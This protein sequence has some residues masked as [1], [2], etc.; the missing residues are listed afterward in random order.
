MPEVVEDIVVELGDRSTHREPYQVFKTALKHVNKPDKSAEDMHADDGLYKNRIMEQHRRDES[1]T[2]LGEE[3]MYQEWKK[4]K[5]EEK[6]RSRLEQWEMRLAEEE[7]EG[8]KKEDREDRRQDDRR[9]R[10]AWTS[11]QPN[12]G[13]GDKGKGD[14]GG[15]GWNGKGKGDQK[16]GKGWPRY[17]GKRSGWKWQQQDQEDKPTASQAAVSSG[18]AAIAPLMAA[19]IAPLLAAQNKAPL[20]SDMPQQPSQQMPTLASPAPMMAAQSPA[21]GHSSWHNGMGM[22]YGNSMGMSNHMAHNMGNWPMDRSQ[23]PHPGGSQWEGYPL[24]SMSH[25]VNNPEQGATDVLQPLGV[26]IG[27]HP[28]KGSA[29]NQAN[30]VQN[31]ETPPPLAERPLWATSPLGGCASG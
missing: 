18:M 10:Q 22:G 28:K 7:G 19:L 30:A 2:D 16:G 20:P 17:R 31:A 5:M 29:K 21:Q 12:A 14:K 15:K 11:S 4:Q 13:K 9:D 24:Q 27:A 1:R 3:E 6:K 23:I 8:Q 26:G 25:H